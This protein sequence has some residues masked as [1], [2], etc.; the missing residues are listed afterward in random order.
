MKSLP[1]R[2]SFR[3][4]WNYGFY[5]HISIKKTVYKILTFL[6]AIVGF[7]SSFY[8]IGVFI[9]LIPLLADLTITLVRFGMNL[10]S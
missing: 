8:F 5:D 4:K 6:A 9:K 2:L 7:F 3:Q 1:P 10:I